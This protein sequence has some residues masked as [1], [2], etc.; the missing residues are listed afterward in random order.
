M[1]KTGLE[2][3]EAVVLQAMEAVQEEDE[4]KFAQILYPV[5][6]G[7]WMA[8]TGETKIPGAAQMKK[9]LSEVEDYG[10]ALPY[11]VESIT[12]AEDYEG[13]SWY[14]SRGYSGLL[15]VDAAVYWSTSKGRTTCHAWPVSF[16]CIY[17]ED[18]WYLNP[19]WVWEYIKS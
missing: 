18:R 17:I 12:E 19:Y 16:Q 13:R 7:E 4:A 2:E 5:P 11:V 6:S 10:F 3:C 8:Q 15:A 14:E 9:V 1:I